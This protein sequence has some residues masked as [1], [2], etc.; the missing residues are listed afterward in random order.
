MPPRT[1][2][3]VRLA[4]TTVAMFATAAVPAQAQPRTPSQTPAR[5]VLQPLVALA[6]ERVLLADRVAA[7]KYGTGAPIDDPSREQQVLDAAAEEADGLGLDPDEARAVFK[8]QIEANKV[9]QRALFRAWDSGAARPPAHRP[10]LGEI[11]PLIDGVNHRLL[12]EL[13]I[14]EG[15]RHTTRCAPRLVAAQRTVTVQLRLSPLHQTGLLR[16]LPSVCPAH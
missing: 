1:R 9:V 16:A 6:A 5:P 3:A 2:A 11:R 13:A 12:A 15:P 8:D 10:T 7:A 4:V 14:T